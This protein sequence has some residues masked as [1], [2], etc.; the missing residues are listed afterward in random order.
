[1]KSKFSVLITV[2]NGDNEIFFSEAM[3]SI[4]N[5][6]RLPNEI[7][8]VCDGLIRSELEDVIFEIKNKYQDL[9]IVRSEINLGLGKALNLGIPLC[10]YEYVARMDSD[11]ISKLD[12]FEIMMGYLDDHPEIDILGSYIEE[13]IDNPNDVLS[14]RRVPIEHKDI[15]KFSR[16][17]S[18]FNHPTVIFKK[19]ALIECG[20]Y[21][22][23]KRNQDLELFGRM[24]FKGYIGHNISKNLLSYRTN[25]A[26]KIRRKSRDNVKSYINIVK[27]FYKNG[28]STLIDYILVC[29]TQ[30]ILLYFPV[31]LTNMA[32]KILRRYY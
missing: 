4:I 27:N 21:S 15:L 5:Q 2:Y 16:R 10:K 31:F 11:D 13:F 7:V 28:H 14:I 26:Q 1:M 12:R 6:S 19:N 30:N 9:V 24:M 17:R 20:G 23:L 8:L 29:I 25:Q 32:D 3:K 18:P 22:T